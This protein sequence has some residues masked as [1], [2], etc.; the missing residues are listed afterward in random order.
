MPTLDTL[1]K[2]AAAQIGF[3]VPIAVCTI[4]LVFRY[5]FRRDAGWLFLYIFSLTRIAGGAV[6]LAAEL[7][8]PPKIDLF[9]AAYVL[10]AAGLAPLLLAS[11]GF[12]GLAGQSSY[13][14][15]SRVS[16]ILRLYG[17]LVITGLALSI[18]GGLLGTHVSPTQGNVG[19]TLRRASAGIFAGVYVFLFM[20]HL[21][22]WTYHFQMRSYRR[23]LLAGLTIALPFLGVRVAYAV[24]SA[25]SS[26]DLFGERPSSNPVLA[27]FNPVTGSWIA[28]L[29]MSLVMEFI[30]SVLYLLFSTV[31]S[32]R[33]S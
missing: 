18:A 27:R 33:Y 29:V 10:Q 21:G 2:I 6:T 12:I 32:R 7:I 5:A 14:E 9:I 3:Y 22:C 15:V 8:E 13:S 1:G 19:L 23:K 26:S 30:V 25:W 24:L 16:I 28:Y 4:I 20:T 31:L 11:I 17:L